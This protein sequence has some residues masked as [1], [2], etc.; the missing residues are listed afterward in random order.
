MEFLDVIVLIL[1]SIIA[2]VL[3]C[4]LFYFRMIKNIANK[5][6]AKIC[7][8]AFILLAFILNPLAKAGY[9]IFTVLN[10]QYNKHFVSILQKSIITPKPK[11]ATKNKNIVYIY[12][13]SFSRNY[14]IKFPNLTPK[15]NSLTNKIDFVNISQ[16]DGTVVTIE[17][18]FGSQCGLPL[19]Y[20]SYKKDGEGNRKFPKNIK[21]SS[22]IL[23]EQ[24]YYTY[25]IKGAD[26]EFEKTRD[27][28]NS[29]A[30]D[31]QKGKTELLKQQNFLLNEWGVNDDDMFDIAFSD[32]IR[33]SE[34]KD[35]FLQVVLTVG[36]HVPNGF[37]SKKCQNLVY[38]DEKNAMLNAVKCTDFLLYDFIDKIRKSKFGKN[39]IIVVQNDHLAPYGLIKGIDE[40]KLSDSNNLFFILDD[41]IDGVQIVENKGSSLDTFTT[42]LG[43]IGIL[44]EMHFGRNILKI[45]SLHETLKNP[46][47][48]YQISMPL[49]PN[50]SDK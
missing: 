32:F 45:K 31:E 49:I 8:F 12:L 38:E 43:Y 5:N 10:P 40:K 1:L 21:C 19:F 23:K 26:L 50:L 35:K 6:M 24:G 11:P 47:Q 18:L 16:A 7:Y 14:L 46:N 44:D 34:T 27:F 28:L 48:I 39:T 15:I 2:G 9:D 33:L 36:T 41:D 30:Y 25:F 17:G 3:F 13:E 37:I 42:L 22:Q 29:R 20:Y 4:V